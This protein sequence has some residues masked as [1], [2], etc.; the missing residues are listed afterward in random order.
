MAPSLPLPPPSIVPSQ[1][2]RIIS[3]GELSL[4][5]GS[6]PSLLAS[7]TSQ[8][9]RSIQEQALTASYHHSIAR[10]TTPSELELPRTGSDKSG[11]SDTASYVLLSGLAAK[12]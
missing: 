11:K 2:H 4:A 1:K 10:R 6:D 12:P 8:L 7:R 3:D 5:E 9:Q